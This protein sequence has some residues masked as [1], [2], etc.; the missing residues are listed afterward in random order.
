MST[1]RAALSRCPSQ[2]KIVFDMIQ[3]DPKPDPRIVDRDAM[4]VARLASDY[5]AA[6]GGEPGSVH[7]VIP[8]SERGDDVAGNLLLLCGNGTM[9]CHGALHG[10]PYVVQVG[11]WCL[12]VERRD[13]AWV[14]HKIGQTI[15]LLRPDVIAYVTGKLG[16]DAGTA[17]LERRYQMIEWRPL[18]HDSTT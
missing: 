6:C 5:C 10:N 8:R 18:G 12:D 1:F 7:H 17:Y 13:A 11:N 3:P 9:G 16:E 2:C 15:L 14:S 4:R